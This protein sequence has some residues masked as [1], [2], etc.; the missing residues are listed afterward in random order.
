MEILAFLI[1][2]I[3]VGVLLFLMIKA[4]WNIFSKVGYPG[5]YGLG[6]LVPFLNFV[7]LLY[8]GFSKWPIH[9]KGKEQAQREEKLPE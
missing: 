2:L 5:W 6:R 7:L 4:W 1:P 9:K 3:I 8:L